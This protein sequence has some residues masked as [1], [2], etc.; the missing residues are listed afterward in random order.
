MAYMSNLLVIFKMP[1]AVEVGLD[2]IKEV[3]L[4]GR[5]K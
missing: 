1:K 5:A 2:R 4:L 3:V